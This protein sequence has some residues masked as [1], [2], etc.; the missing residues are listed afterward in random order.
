MRGNNQYCVLLGV[1]GCE[2]LQ[3]LLR[4]FRNPN[5]R[6]A[7]SSYIRIRVLYM[8]IHMLLFVCVS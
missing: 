3:H 7:Y 1:R 6:K 8:L 5:P 4:I 2:P